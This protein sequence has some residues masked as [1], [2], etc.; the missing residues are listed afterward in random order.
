M[1]AA[2]TI[3]TVPVMAITGTVTRG[4]PAVLGNVASVLL[5][6][7]V[8]PTAIGFFHVLWYFQDIWRRYRKYRERGGS[9]LPTAEMSYSSKA[10]SLQARSRAKTASSVAWIVL[11]LVWAYLDLRSHHL[12]P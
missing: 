1:G 8:T 5:V 3:L 7:I 9:G 12:V 2:L 10:P 6:V 4:N 11:I